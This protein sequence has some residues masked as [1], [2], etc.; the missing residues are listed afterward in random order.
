[1][2]DSWLTMAMHEGKSKDQSEAWQKILHYW[3]ANAV[4]SDLSSLDQARSGCRCACACGVPYLSSLTRHCG[5]C[6][7]SRTVY[8]FPTLPSGVLEVILQCLL[9]YFGFVWHPVACVL[10]DLH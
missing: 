6:S 8:W 10:A 7:V 5:D 1:M 9:V 2:R 4:C 3:Q